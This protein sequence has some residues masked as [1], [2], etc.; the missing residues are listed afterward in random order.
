VPYLSEAEQEFWRRSMRES[1][2]VIGDKLLMI[3]EAF[4]TVLKGV[5]IEDMT[6]GE[7]IPLRRSSPV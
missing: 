1:P 5:V 3:L 7:R 6:T 2:D 4:E